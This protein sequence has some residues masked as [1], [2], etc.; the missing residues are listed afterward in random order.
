MMPPAAPEPMTTKSTSVDG[1]NCLIGILQFQRLSAAGLRFRIVITERWLELERVVEPNQL[2]A[3]LV[4]IAAVNR[5][6]EETNDRVIPNGVEERALFDGR[7]QF[8]SAAAELSAENFGALGN[9]SF[10]FA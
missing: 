6:C 9:I 10:V 5:V 7:Q 3:D 2:E 8:E 4:V 1:V